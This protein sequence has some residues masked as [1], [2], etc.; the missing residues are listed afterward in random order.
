MR[1]ADVRS[2]SRRR[3]LKRAAAATAASSVA[4]VS[5]VVCGSLPQKRHGPSPSCS[6]ITL[7]H[8]R[9]LY[10]SADL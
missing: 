10:S 3:F 8:A 9:Q 7:P 4:P 2:Y 5:R 1:F 6:Q